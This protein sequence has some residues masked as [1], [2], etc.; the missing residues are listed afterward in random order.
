MI[1]LN[2][3]KDYVDIDG[4]DLKELAVKVTKAGINVEKVV[5]NHIDNLVIG[6]VLECVEHPDSDHLHVCQVNIGSKVT[7]IVCGASNVR[8][9]LKVIVALPGAVLPGNFEIKASKIRGVESNGMI[10]ALYELGL[11]EKTEE[12]Y[13]RGIQELNSD[14]PVGIDPLSYL[15]IDDTLYELDVHKHRN[16][17]CYYHIGFAYEIASVLNKK[18]TLPED[19][20][21][22]V[23]DNINNHFSLSVETEKCPYYL[24]K[25]V[26]GIEIKESPDFIKKRLT[27]AGMRPINNVVDISNYVMLEYGQPMHFFDKDKLGNKIVV[28]DA[29]EE[30]KITTLDEK[31]R[32]LKDRDIVITDGDKAVCIAGVM[33]GLNTDV[34]DNTKNILIESAIFD[35]TSIRYTA[36]H[37]NLRSEA[38]IRYGKGLN[39]EY[40]EKAILRAC[41]LLEKYA[42]A[43]VLSGMIT[44]DVIDKTDKKVQFKAEDV[45]KLLGI[46]ISTDDMKIELERLG[47]D[48]QLDKDTFDVIIPKRRLDID[49]NV[50]DIAEEIG[51]L[52]GYHNLTSTLPRVPLRR[53]QYIG[54]VKYRKLIS[55]RLRMLGLNECKTYTL[56]SPDMAK[57]FKYENKVNVVLPNP[58]SIDKSI[59]RTSVLPSLLNIYEYNKSRKVNDVLLYEISKVYDVD[60]VEDTKIAFLMKGNYINNGWQGRVVKVDFYLV[61]GIVENILDYLGLKNRYSFEISDCSDL[62]PGMSANILLDREVIGVIGRVHPL[63]HKDEIYVGELSLSK[64]MEKNVKPIKY[65]E[66]SKY[67]AISKDMA[68]VVKKDVM[69]KDIME[70]IKKA[71]GRLLVDVNV[72]DVYVG[73]NV[74]ED[75]KSIAFNL[76]FQEP[77]RTLNDDEV[78]QLFN[79]AIEAVTTKMGAILRDK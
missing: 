15:G 22:E 54:D 60:F 64:I 8:T 12:A 75:E 11:E 16:N 48:Y 14:A 65:K 34:D 70:V 32:V 72:F 41:H 42:N 18:V 46:T 73:E 40:T 51:R 63:V 66:S 27:A 35:A 21:K 23:S 76:T 33:G 25:M 29:Y 7:Q 9:G 30:E 52:Y 26:T 79:K 37:L 38:S 47:F 31:E 59:V 13:N 17:D 3:V 19:D 36:G 49:P 58:M 56:T 5:T 77:T 28:R 1:S 20:F 53:G 24:A 57:L 69:A 61:K 6:E 43:K 10:C 74:G 68:F 4:M 67:P 55:K 44:H 2:W 45:N 78:M 39:Y 71:C 50:N 62:H